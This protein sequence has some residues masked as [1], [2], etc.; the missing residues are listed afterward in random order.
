MRLSFLNIILLFTSNIYYQETSV[1]PQTSKKIREQLKYH[2]TQRNYDSA[3]YYVDE[4]IKFETAE[5]DPGMFIGAHFVKNHPL[6][7]IKK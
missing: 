3:I 2:R 5:K 7:K 6:K 1:K 4:L